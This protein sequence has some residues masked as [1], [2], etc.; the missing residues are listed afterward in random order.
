[1]RKT[2]LGARVSVVLCLLVLQVPAQPLVA[3]HYFYWYRWPDSH[4]N[5]PGAPGREGHT[6]HLKSPERT[7]WLDPDWHEQQLRDMGAAGIDVA[8]PVYW[9]APGAY[10]RP[11]LRWAVEGIPPMVRAAER[12]GPRGVK[13][14]LFYDTST[15]LNR[16][17]GVAPANGRADLSTARGK[18]LF[19]GTVIEYFARI[20]RHL[21]GRMRGRPLV[22]LYSSG[23]AA[24]WDRGLGRVLR[25]R[26]A[27]RFEGEQPFLV[28]DASWGDIGQ[29][30]TTQWGAAL[31]GPRLFDG[32]AQIG[33]GYDDSPVPGRSTPIRE[34]EN[35]AFYTNA[36]R[37]AIKHRPELVL[38]ETWNE[39]H[40]GT[41]I[42]ETIETG[43]S[44]IRL[45]RLGVRR[46]RR[47]AWP[48]SP[49][50]LRWPDPRPRPDRSW[51]SRAKGV[52]RVR[53]DWVGATP[54]V[55]IRH[56][57]WEDGPVHRRTGA[58]VSPGAPGVRYV[59]LQVS[60][61]WRFDVAER[62]GKDL[63]LDVVT[64]EA[65]E[66]RVQYDGW[67]RRAPLD[68]AY[69]PA[70]KVPTDT[71]ERKR[72]RLPRV[73]FANRQNGGADLRLVLTGPDVRLRSVTLTPVR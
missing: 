58:L 60:D 6:H 12:L 56:R 46:L 52:A 19:C 7:S 31:A 70:V 72:F 23:F 1:M 9:G 48:G 53:Q 11:G 67:D 16:V 35:G 50:R 68:G 43:R 3:T 71:P 27:N 73:R 13:L 54:G 63:L 45:T 51:G 29:D 40:E 47:G 10:Q 69:S 65:C 49:V 26:F 66:I 17:R 44:Y 57:A 64:A 25:A 14:G 8:L 22:V 42:C 2:A 4:F 5:Q 28:A 41:E 39:L 36:W 55:G 30:R 33:P 24:R 62:P 21:W 59:Y 18:D 61:H 15:L 37:A 38:I 20:P 34:R 32:V